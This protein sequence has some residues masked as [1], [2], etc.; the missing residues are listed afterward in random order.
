MDDL[1]AVRVLQRGAELRDQG[2]Q[3]IPGQ[4]AGRLLE[5]DGGQRRPV[6]VFHDNERRPVRVLVQVVNADDVGMGQFVAAGGFAAQIIQSAR[7]AANFRRQELQRHR[8]PQ[9]FIPGQPD[10][11]HAAAPQAF[12]EDKPPPRKSLFRLQ[13]HRFRHGRLY[14]GRFCNNPSASWQEQMR[15]SP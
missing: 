1:L 15:H 3:I 12:D 13:W 10:L 7:I 4:H 6:N 8:F 11:A 9:P 14:L 5:P 2:P